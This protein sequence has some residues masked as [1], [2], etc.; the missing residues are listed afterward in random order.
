MGFN[1]PK[2]H[3]GYKACHS[4]GLQINFGHLGIFNVYQNL[5]TWAAFR[6]REKGPL[7]PGSNLYSLA[8]QHALGTKLSQWLRKKDVPRLTP[9]GKVCPSLFMGQ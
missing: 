5:D 9:G 1:T 4:G 8:Q 6:L 3:L 2:L 7:Q